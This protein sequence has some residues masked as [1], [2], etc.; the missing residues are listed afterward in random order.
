M[1]WNKNMPIFK[2]KIL[3]ISQ[4][5]ILRIVALIS[6]PVLYHL[7]VYKSQRLHSLTQ[8]QVTSDV[9]EPTDCNNKRKSK[10]LMKPNLSI[11]FT[12]ISEPS[13]T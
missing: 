12:M 11:K 4:L 5:R 2:F 9:D 7:I 13:K 1:S 3:T 8:E 6:K 10:R